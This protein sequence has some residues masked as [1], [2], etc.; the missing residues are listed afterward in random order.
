MS[1]EIH[2]KKRGKIIFWGEHNKKAI[3]KEKK[4]SPILSIKP[5]KR[6]YLFQVVWLA[7]LHE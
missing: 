6:V 2:K 7:D 3:K 5:E 4:S 1:R